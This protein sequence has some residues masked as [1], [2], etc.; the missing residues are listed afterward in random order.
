MRY[1]SDD[2]VVRRI[3]VSRED[4]LAPATGLLTAFT[5]DR[6]FNSS[7]FR[8]L[9]QSIAAS[10]LEQEHAA[11]DT[12]DDFAR[13]FSVGRQV[14]SDLFAHWHEQ[15]WIRRRPAKSR[16]ESQYTLTTTGAARFVLQISENKQA[17]ALARFDRLLLALYLAR[18]MTIDKLEQ[19]FPEI[20]KEI[21][22]ARTWNWSSMRRRY[23][24]HLRA[25]AQAL[26]SQADD[27]GAA[28]T[29][30]STLLPA[31]MRLSREI[32]ERIS[33]LP[34]GQI[35]LQG[36]EIEVPDAL[37][38]FYFPALVPFRNQRDVRPIHEMGFQPF[39]NFLREFSDDFID[40]YVRRGVRDMGRVVIRRYAEHAT[41]MA[42][43][44][45]AI[46][47]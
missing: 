22:D 11:T 9:I 38:G 5:R 29:K 25:H 45:D 4:I 1:E 33:V 15:G 41:A 19:R 10:L 39:R 35:S 34:S 7:L 27:L 47:S 20:R 13:R 6:S 17:L 44:L 43:L 42:D 37:Q 2:S 36:F 3:H 30:L 40:D 21:G 32:I 18:Q 46:E 23:V 8:K 31:G 14:L 28:V 24:R 16:T 12:H 26:Y